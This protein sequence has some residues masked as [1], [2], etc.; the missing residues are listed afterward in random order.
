MNI[1]ED[2]NSIDNKSFAKNG[3]VVINTAAASPDGD[4][5]AFEVGASGVTVT[6]I[7]FGDYASLYNGLDALKDFPFVEGNTYF[8]RFKSIT[9]SAGNLICYK[10]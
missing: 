8:V 2:I 6:A 7:D 10:T 4:Y 9:I 1:F 5:Y 3:F